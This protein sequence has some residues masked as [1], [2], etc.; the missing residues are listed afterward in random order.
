[1]PGV[2]RPAMSDGRALTNW[3]GACELNINLQRAS[4]VNSESEYRAKLQQNPRMFDNQAKRYVDYMPYQGVGDCPD[5][6]QAQAQTLGDMRG[7][8]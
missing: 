6:A 7:R 1:M 8:Y 3:L 2:I 4:G 5:A